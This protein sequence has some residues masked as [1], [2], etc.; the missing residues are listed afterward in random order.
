MKSRVDFPDYKEKVDKKFVDQP[1]NVYRDLNIADSTARVEKMELY[2]KNLMQNDHSSYLK[3]TE[4]SHLL[5]S[6]D[7]DLRQLGSLKSA[8]NS[9]EQGVQF[10]SISAE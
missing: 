6:S 4:L 9:D 1:A 8:F 3:L 7:L 2:M 10:A 5:Q